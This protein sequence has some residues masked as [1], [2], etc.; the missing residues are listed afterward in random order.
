[1]RKGLWPTYTQPLCCFFA[2]SLGGGKKQDQVLY[3]VKWN[4]VQKWV[5]E[6]NNP[7]LTT[8]GP[9]RTAVVVSTVGVSSSCSVN[10]DNREPG[11]SRFSS[12]AL[13][14]RSN[15]HP[16]LLGSQR[17][18]HLDTRGSRKSFFLP[19]Q[20]LPLLSPFQFL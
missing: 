18:R 8:T 15:P 5:G 12:N 9:S 16:R 17:L 13:H 3:C 11:V 19:G 10:N 20:L 14:E 6:N 4:W 1:M 7:F 2:Q